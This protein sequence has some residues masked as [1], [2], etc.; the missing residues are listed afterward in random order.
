MSLHV[1]LQ[2]QQ[3]L[4]Y[5]VKEDAGETKRTTTVLGILL[6]I[7]INRNNLHL[8]LM[9]LWVQARSSAFVTKTSELNKFQPVKED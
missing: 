9:N 1:H 7:K 4:C 5:K 8:E 2:A 3:L 6:Q